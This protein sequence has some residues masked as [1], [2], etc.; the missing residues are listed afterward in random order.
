MYGLV[1]IFLM[2]ILKKMVDLY[3][4]N[5]NMANV[6]WTPKTLA[7]GASNGDIEWYYD[8]IDDYIAVGGDIAKQD[9]NGCTVLDYVFNDVS[10]VNVVDVVAFLISRGVPV[11]E[12]HITDCRET[13]RWWLE[14]KLSW[15]RK[16]KT[17]FP[18]NYAKFCERAEK[19]I[20][21]YEELLTILTE[22]YNATH[23][24]RDITC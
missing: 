10:D 15:S 7:L 20:A 18:E 3:A 21:M 23:D 2:I 4:G 5:Y 13:I 6:N 14:Q 24:E 11:E 1:F 12:R 17:C 22:R 8:D 9:D 19:E 16:N